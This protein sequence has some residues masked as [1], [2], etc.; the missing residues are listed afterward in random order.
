MR[1]L[2]ILL[3]VLALLVPAALR[4]QGAITVVATNEPL[5][6]VLKLISAQTE[7]S[8]VY[9]TDLIDTSRKITIAV[10]SDS[11]EDVLDSLSAVC[12][13][14]YTIVGKQI[15]FS[16]PE[17]EAPKAD[18]KART[19]TIRGLVT[20]ESGEPLAGADVYV[21]LTRTGVYTDMNGRYSIELPDNPDTE[22][23]FDFI[24]MEPAVRR[25]GS[26][27]TINV[28][29]YS[30]ASVLNQ[31]VVTGYQTISRERSAGAFASV[32]GAT[33]RDQA[34]IHGNVLRSLEGSAAG[35]SVSET[36]DGVTYLIRGVSSINS[37][38]EPL[39]IVDGVAM[40]R[41]QMDKM[42]NPNDVESINFLKDATAASIW[43]A[44]AANGVIVVTTKKG[45]SG[46]LRI[47]YNGSF[48]FK[49]KPDWKYMDM[50]DSQ[51]F[52]ETA[53]EVF[54]PQTYK[55][56]DVQGNTYGT[57]N[58]YRV[59][60]PHEYPLY[61]YY[62]GE[63]SL[64]ERDAA[65]AALA[66][67]NG[68][69]EYERYFMSDAYLMNHS[70]SFSGGS[71]ISNFYVSLEYQREKGVNKDSENEYRLFFRDG[72]KLAS[73]LDL[74]I[75][76]HL[77]YSNSK[78]Y[79]RSHALPDLPY[80]SYYGQD[81]K[82]L[83]LT[84]YVMT[85]AYRQSIE[86]I[87]GIGLNYF[88]VSDYLSCPVTEKA[89]GEQI[90]DEAR[91]VGKF[92]RK[93]V[94]NRLTGKTGTVKQLTGSANLDAEKAAAKFFSEIGL[95]YFAWPQAQSKPDGLTNRVVLNIDKIR[96]IRI[97]KVELDPKKFQLIEGSE[98]E[99]PLDSF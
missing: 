69:R 8:F 9:N 95:E 29:L 21:A 30:Q 35:L 15:A 88:P 11:I 4:A 53:V 16:V 7:Y 23:T 33:V 42:L 80:M 79:T 93:Y 78:A 56:A 18:G 14:K 63:I 26:H 28:M 66:A 70:V 74:D 75:S 87:T 41:E 81:G 64:A 5:S 99:I 71:E 1:K 55:W 22:L 62:I 12:G 37:K 83:S 31:S 25:I 46:D 57:G 77:F 61:R 73:W 2:A 48:T 51:R 43:G 59:T 60:Y 84:N 98:K 40:T 54:D 3:T 32:S 24:G 85:D 96:I 65:L 38:R 91:A 39:F 47:N 58:A 45:R 97:D 72:L 89:L 49:G 10:S 44:Q 34:N 76:A 68:R 50:M 82:E 86:G 20:D 27:S 6:T 13:I 94:G 17:P 92:F 90:P 67:V 36:A 19:R 52:I